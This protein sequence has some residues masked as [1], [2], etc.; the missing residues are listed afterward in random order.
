MVTKFTEFHSPE[1]FYKSK[2]VLA[3]YFYQIKTTIVYLLFQENL[4]LLHHIQHKL[5][6]PVEQKKNSKIL[7]IIPVYILYQLPG[8]PLKL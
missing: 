6:L 8:L 7:K 2:E 3:L 4:Q 1:F 5:H